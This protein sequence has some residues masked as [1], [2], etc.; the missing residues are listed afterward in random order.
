MT[1]NPYVALVVMAPIAVSIGAL[2]TLPAW[3]IADYHRGRI[4][5]L[6]DE[7]WDELF[8]APNRDTLVGAEALLGRM[9]DVTALVGGAKVAAPPSAARVRQAA[10]P[11]ILESSL[12]AD[13]LAYVQRYEADFQTAAYNVVAT[14]SWSRLLGYLFAVARPY[15]GGPEL[16]KRL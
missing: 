16:V 6:R 5:R 11:T 3:A 4:W 2:F 7:L 9:S 10:A 8:D 13:D 14:R 12:A 15:W 1:L